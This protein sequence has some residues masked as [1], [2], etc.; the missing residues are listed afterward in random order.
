MS[1]A[2]GASLKHRS[3]DAGEPEL[4]P[5]PQQPASGHFAG[6]PSSQGGRA[7]CLG[8]GSPT[9]RV[10]HVHQLSAEGCFSRRAQHEQKKNPEHCSLKS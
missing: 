9:L 5:R 10:K 7:T 6:C 3:V 1:K 8:R 4:R 2:L